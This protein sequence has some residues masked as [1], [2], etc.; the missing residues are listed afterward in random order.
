MNDAA[1]VQGYVVANVRRIIM[2]SY[3]CVSI[4]IPIWQMHTEDKLV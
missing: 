1:A 3:A 4:I 2:L